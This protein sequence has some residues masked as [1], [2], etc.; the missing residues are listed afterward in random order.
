MQPEAGLLPAVNTVAALPLPVV[1]R[2]EPEPELLELMPVQSAQTQEVL[3]NAV[4]E[5]A[6]PAE[7]YFPVAHNFAY[8]T[9]FSL[10]II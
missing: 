8:N 9:T 6:E 3:Y 4:V 7:D 1:V 10:P 2:I 5:A